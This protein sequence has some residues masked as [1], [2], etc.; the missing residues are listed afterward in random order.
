MN[1]TVREINNIMT[2]YILYFPKCTQDFLTFKVKM[3]L[4][5]TKHHAMKV[6]WGSGDIALCIL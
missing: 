2:F 3:S 4:C 5:L 1:C 6:F